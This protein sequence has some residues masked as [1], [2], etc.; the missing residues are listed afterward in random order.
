MTEDQKKEII[1]LL[2]LGAEIIEDS[3]FRKWDN[4]TSVRSWDQWWT[5]N[6]YMRSLCNEMTTQA[7]ELEGVSNE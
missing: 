5:D 2:R 7:N 1:R 6:I 3:E 4:S